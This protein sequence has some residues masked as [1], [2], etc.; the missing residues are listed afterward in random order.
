MQQRQATT[1]RRGR[2]DSGMADGLADDRCLWCHADC[3]VVV[4]SCKPAG[5]CINKLCPGCIR[6]FVHDGSRCLVCRESNAA[7]KPMYVPLRMPPHGVDVDRLSKAL[8]F[9]LVGSI[10]VT[11]MVMIIVFPTIDYLV[12]K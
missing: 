1:G 8:A 7:G 11:T 3:R 5:G 6:E 2:M 12:K 9:T 10:V 4:F